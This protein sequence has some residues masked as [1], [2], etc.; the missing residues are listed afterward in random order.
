MADTKLT[1][2][3]ANTTP[4]DADLLYL[5]DAGSVLGQKITLA[6]LMTKAPYPLQVSCVF[7]PDPADA[8]TYYFGIP[9]T[10][11]NTTAARRRIYIP[12]AGTVTAIYVFANFLN[13]SSETSTLSFRLNNT[14][15]TTITSSV[16][17]NSAP[18]AASNTALSIAVA[19]GD[20][21]EFKWVTPTWATNPT[22][23]TWGGVVW[24]T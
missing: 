4:A 9:G 15:D 10:A 20:Y 17:M 5:V 2:L 8:T 19:T 6:N 7:S 18:F 16:A 11:Q 12:R 14:T 22:A 24:I 21:F 3:T 1:G 13:G 23:V